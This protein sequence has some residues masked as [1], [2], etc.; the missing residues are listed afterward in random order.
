MKSKS[1]VLFMVAAGCGLVAMVGVQQ[2][3]SGKGKQVPRVKVLVARAEVEPGVK[4][5]DDLVGFK[6]IPKDAVPEGAVTKAEEYD[7]RALKSRAFPGNVIQVAQLGEKGQFG[8]SLDIPQGMRLVSVPVNSTMIHSGIMKPGDRVDLVLTYEVVKRGSGRNFLTKTILQYVQV[9]A[10]GDTRLGSEAAESGGAA[11]DVKNISLL[12][13]QKQAELIQFALRLGTIMPTL[14]S[15]LDTQAVST[16]VTDAETLQALKADLIE[17]SDV[18]VAEAPT[19]PAAE[20][21]P[22]EKP[23]F[24]E[25]VQAEP[26]PAPVVTPEPVKPTWKIEIYEGQDKKTYELELPTP[27]AETQAAVPAANAKGIWTSPLLNWIGGQR[28]ERQTAT[29]LTP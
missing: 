17:V 15:T 19:P 18:K 2:M 7:N 21:K 25:F 5:T 3:M 23:S 10:L 16:E 28:R 8:T 24:A 26:T 1:I 4:L 13:T 14:R 27:A 6:E 22:A 9:Y 29:T 12:L 11:K 20:P